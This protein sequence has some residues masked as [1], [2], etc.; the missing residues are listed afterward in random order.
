MGRAAFDELTE[1][2]KELVATAIRYGP[3]PPRPEYLPDCHRLHE[4]GWFDIGLTDD[5]VFFSLST[6]GEAALE[7]GVPLAE[8]REAMN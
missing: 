6:Q 5:H 2:Q 7:L 3:F 4:R 8:A 1:D